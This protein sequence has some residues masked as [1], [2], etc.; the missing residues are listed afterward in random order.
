[1]FCERGSVSGSSCTAY[2]GVSSLEKK[3]GAFMKLN[4]S[5]MFNFTP[6]IYLCPDPKPGLN[7]D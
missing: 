4:I 5:M 1:M 3:T 2:R 7:Q 6:V